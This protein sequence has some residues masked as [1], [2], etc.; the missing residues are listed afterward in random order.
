M[1]RSLVAS[2]SRLRRN[3]P[4]TSRYSRLACN[5]VRHSSL[6]ARLRR[7]RDS[8]PRVAPAATPPWA[9]VARA[10]LAR[11][12]SPS[13]SPSSSLP[14]PPPYRRVRCVPIFTT[15]C[16]ALYVTGDGRDAGGACGY[17]GRSFQNLIP[18]K[19]CR[20]PGTISTGR[21]TDRHD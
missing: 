9:Q 12:R 17:Y 3:T 14:P 13:P 20:F 7:R 4:P 5:E 11:N 19:K 8:V 18:S 21:S 6:L 15:T 16:R 1:T 10:R 2:F